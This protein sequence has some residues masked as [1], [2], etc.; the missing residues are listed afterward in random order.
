MA[1]STR[2][3]VG[4]KPLLYWLSE[5]DVTL[6]AS[7]LRAFDVEDRPEGHLRFPPGCLWTPQ[8]GVVRYANGVP[9]EVRPAHRSPEDEWDDGV[10]KTVREALIHAVD[11]R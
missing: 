5:D 11:A 7:E 1:W 8:A 3:P 6:F 9:V 2:D 4:V 10:L